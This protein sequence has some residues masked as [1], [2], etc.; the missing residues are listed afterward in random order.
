M[1]NQLN[2]FLL[3]LNNKKP[4]Y[5][6]FKLYFSFKRIFKFFRTK[7]IINHINKDWIDYILSKVEEK[8]SVLIKERKKIRTTWKFTVKSLT[9]NENN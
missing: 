6:L 7:I 2:L 4:L 5:G 1:S 8:F 3:K 9:I